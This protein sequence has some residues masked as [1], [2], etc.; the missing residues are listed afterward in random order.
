MTE[1][2]PAKVFE[3]LLVIVGVQ[4]SAH[5]LMEL[6]INISYFVTRSPKIR[7]K[8][9]KYEDNI[10]EVDEGGGVTG[11]FLPEED[12]KDV[13]VEERLWALE[14]GAKTESQIKELVLE[15]RKLDNA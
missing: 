11:Q 1:F 12:D 4:L 3:I 7:I 10:V 8:V 2:I 13:T 14:Q 6:V 5:L 9:P 15:S